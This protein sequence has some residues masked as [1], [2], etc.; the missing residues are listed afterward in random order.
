VHLEASARLARLAGDGHDPA[1]QFEAILSSFLE[2]IRVEGLRGARPRVNPVRWA[3]RGLSTT[4]FT[5]S[6]AGARNLAREVGCD[7][8]FVVTVKAEAVA[9][10][11]VA[12]LNV[13]VAGRRA[14]SVVGL[15]VSRSYEVTKERPKQLPLR[16]ISGLEEVCREAHR[17][18]LAVAAHCGWYDDLDDLV[19]AVD[20]LGAATI[21]HGV[22]LARN[23]AAQKHVAD[24]G[25]QVEVCPTAYVRVGGRPLAEHPLLQWLD[26]GVDVVI[27]TDHPLELDVTLP[28]E[29][30]LL[31]ATFPQLGEAGGEA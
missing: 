12:A 20:V 8:A 25:V 2:R 10:D 31:L 22:P 4:A 26:H 28:S 14:E 19:F 23:E 3:R 11:L 5:K 6:T 9:D 24:R 17:R 7:L 21:G 15:D 16:A 13:A 1:Q 27:G 29:A 30:A 18:D